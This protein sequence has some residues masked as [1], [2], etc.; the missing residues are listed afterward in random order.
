MT[1]DAKAHLIKR[2]AAQLGFDRVGIAPA[3]AT[4]NALHYRDWLARGYAGT[5]RYL[6]RNVPMRENAAQL[7]SDSR[8]IWVTAIRYRTR[9]DAA[10]TPPPETPTGRVAQYARGNDYHTV[11]RRR[12]DELVARVRTQITDTFQARTF[13]DTGPVLERD[14][15]AVAGLGW[16]GKNTLLMHESLGSYLFLAVAITTLDAA[17]DAPAANHC[18]TCT[19]CLDACPTQAFPQ[20]YVL[21]ARRCISYLTIE[22]RSEI[23]PALA[24]RMGDWVYGCDVCQ[25]VCPFNHRAPL[26][27]DA[28]LTQPR[29]A[30]RLPLLPLTQLTNEQHRQLT[31]GTAT[32]RARADMWRRN[33]AIALANQHRSARRDDTPNSNS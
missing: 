3:A 27:S 12:M 25:E 33:A 2:V 14:L 18:G 26:A 13:V 4:P 11:L 1:P 22:H 23:D 5:M 19:R 29:I 31:A 28:E 7:L 6:E 32:D 16:I 24:Q 8:T 15:A 10:E 17:I 21:D 9:E 30:A 20:P